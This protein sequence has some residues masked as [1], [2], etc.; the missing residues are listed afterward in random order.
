MSNVAHDLPNL[1]D[2]HRIHNAGSYCYL[3]D[4]TPRSC[5]YTKRGM[6]TALLIFDVTNFAAHGAGVFYLEMLFIKQLDWRNCVDW[7]H[8][9]QF[10]NVLTSAMK[11]ISLKRCLIVSSLFLDASAW[12]PTVTIDA[13]VIVGTAV[14]LSSATA[15]VNEFLGVPFAQSPPERFSPPVSPKRWEQPLETVKWKPACIQQFN[16]RSTYVNQCTN[17][18]IRCRSRVK[19]QFY[20]G[21]IQQSSTSGKR[22]LPLFERICSVYSSTP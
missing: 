17:V 7:T 3:D 18:L 20:I 14:S 1:Y 11:N 13:G 5:R 8:L 9:P 19:P 10:S 2:H 4:R 22:R 15:P 16:C 21:C 6:L 12:K